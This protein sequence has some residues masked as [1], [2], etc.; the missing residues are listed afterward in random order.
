MDLF[1]SDLD[2]TLIFSHRH[3]EE[4]DVCVERLEGREQS[5]C[6]SREPALLARVRERAEFI[7][8]T[9]R[10]VEQY[11]RIQWP[12]DCAPRYAVTDNGGILLCDGVE[13]PRWREE[14]RTAAEPWEGAL[15]QAQELLSHTPMLRRW[16]LVDGQIGRASCRERV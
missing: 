7:P 13:D 16:G 4:G 6:T 15:R 5:F 3:R 10:S 12:P 2:N 8:V 14:T 9:T 1:A 11:R